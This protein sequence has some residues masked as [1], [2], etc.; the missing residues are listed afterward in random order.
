MSNLS[1]MRK[2][3]RDL[4]KESGHRPISKMKKAD[5]AHELERLR[6]KRETVP[7]VAATH[8]AAPRRLAPRAAH[9]H[10][11]KEMEHPVKPVAK[12][13]NVSPPSKKSSGDTGSSS[14]KDMMQKMLKM[15]EEMD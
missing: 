3:L 10:E 13:E 9:V 15:L 7:P 2:E 12:K 1:D 14:K 11:S 4:R 8:G 5:V 6:E